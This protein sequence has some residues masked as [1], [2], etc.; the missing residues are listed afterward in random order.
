MILR[1]YF[2]KVTKHGKLK[3]RYEG[4]A[5]AQALVAEAEKILGREH[6]EYIKQRVTGCET[7]PE[8]VPDTEDGTVLDAVPETVLDTEDTRPHLPFDDVGFTV[9][10]PKWVKNPPND[11]VSRVGLVCAVR[12]KM[13]AY[14]FTSTAKHNSGTHIT[15][16]SLTFVSVQPRE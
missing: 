10:L 5:S 6:S 16:V 4:E 14:D 2:C 3:F 15:G 8:T 1:G 13:I 12:V 9:I 7:V 11:I